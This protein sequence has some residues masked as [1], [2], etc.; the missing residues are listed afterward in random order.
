LFNDLPFE[1]NLIILDSGIDRKYREVFKISREKDFEVFVIRIIVPESILKKRIKNRNK[2]GAVEY[3]K[4]M[5]IW[6]RE[7]KKCSGDVEADVVLQ[8]NINNLDDVFKKLERLLE[9]R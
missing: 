4:S 9:H 2:E 6:K 3:F 1:N 7:F 8:E 5:E